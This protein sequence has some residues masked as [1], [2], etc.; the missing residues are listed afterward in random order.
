M[1]YQE[2]QN[3]IQQPNFINVK[4]MICTKN[5]HVRKNSEHSLPTGKYSDPL[6][7]SMPMVSTTKDAL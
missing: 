3:D 6:L 2:W 7:Q 4:D 1:L 5:N